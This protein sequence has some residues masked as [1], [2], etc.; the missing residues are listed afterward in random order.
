MHEMQKQ[1]RRLMIDSPDGCVLPDSEPWFSPR[2]GGKCTFTYAKTLSD[3][4]HRSGSSSLS[5]RKKAIRRMPYGF[6]WLG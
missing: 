2:C 3:A 1:Q 6:L 4:G 5:K